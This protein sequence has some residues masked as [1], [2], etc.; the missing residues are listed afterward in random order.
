MSIATHA[1]KFDLTKGQLA[2][3]VTEN[4]AKR[5]KLGEKMGAKPLLSTEQQEFV[6]DTIIRYDRG[7]EGKSVGEMIDLTADTMPGLSREQCRHALRRTVRH[8]YEHRLTGPI[9][10]QATTTKRSAITIDQQW[11]RDK[12][13]DNAFRDQEAWNAAAPSSDGATFASVAD[14]FVWNGDEECLLASDGTV[15]IL[16]ERGRAKHEKRKDDSRT[17]ITLY[18]CGSAAGA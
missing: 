1:T 13:G 11:R 4:L 7:N 8:R 17:S 6:A 18:R 9:K 16:G 3:F 2:P 15:D 10:A 5:R 12:C 14:H